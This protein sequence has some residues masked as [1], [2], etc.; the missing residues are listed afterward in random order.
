MKKI[1]VVLIILLCVFI[2]NIFAISS[3]NFKSNINTISGGGVFGSSSYKSTNSLKPTGGPIETSLVN[4]FQGMLFCERLLFF[5]QFTF[6]F[7]FSLFN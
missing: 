5:V 7:Y 3:T 4:C 2:I 6:V 1:S